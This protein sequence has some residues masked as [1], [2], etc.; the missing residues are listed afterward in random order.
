[1]GGHRNGAKVKHEGGLDFVFEWVA[2]FAS[3]RQVGFELNGG[4]YDALVM[5][6]TSSSFVTQYLRW[7]VTETARQP[8]QFIT[9]FTELLG[10]KA[11]K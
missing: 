6:S 4:G 2:C 10:S 5:S 9:E 11:Q 3:V 1:M 8:V 7:I